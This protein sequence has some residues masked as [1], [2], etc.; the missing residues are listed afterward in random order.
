MKDETS[1][2]PINGFV[3]LKSKMYTFIAE[4]NHEAKNLKGTNNNFVDNE[5]K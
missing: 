2:V 1:G 5:L 4:D 3:G